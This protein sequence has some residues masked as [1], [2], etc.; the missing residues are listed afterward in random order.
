MT[1]TGPQP[2][3][4]VREDQMVDSQ[5]ASHGRATGWESTTD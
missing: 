2:R 5:I 1:P 3:A 4:P